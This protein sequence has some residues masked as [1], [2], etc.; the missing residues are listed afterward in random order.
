MSLFGPNGCS[1]LSMMLSMLSMMLSMMS[2]L[3]PG[4]RAIDTRGRFKCW[5]KWR[6]G[7]AP[8]AM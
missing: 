7:T 1:M 4:A 5:R 2:D 3:V 6:R 8:E